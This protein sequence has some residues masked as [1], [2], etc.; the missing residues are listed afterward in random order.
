MKGADLGLEH[1]AP[2]V[3]ISGTPYNGRPDGE[4][5]IEFLVAKGYPRE[6]FLSFGHNARST[7]EEAIAL[8][9]EL[10]RRNVKHVILVTS[11]YHSRRAALVFHLFCPGIQFLSI[12]APDDSYHPDVWWKDPSS[13]HLFFSEW[14][15]V[16]ATVLIVYPRYR[17]ETLIGL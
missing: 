13:R 6:M 17:A 10:I 14:S 12:P 2:L 5:A 3:M 1:Y 15:K 4:L 11:A 16:I 7:I 9:P 8:R